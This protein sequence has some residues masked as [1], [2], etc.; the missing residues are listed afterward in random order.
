MVVGVRGKNQDQLLF[1]WSWSLQE[2]VNFND[3]ETC[4]KGGGGQRAAQEHGNVNPPPTLFLEI[5]RNLSIRS[6]RRSSF[7]P[8]LPI[9][10]SSHQPINQDG[11]NTNTAF[12]DF[13]HF[14][15]LINNHP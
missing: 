1:S 13:H 11:V 15:K 4:Y 12:D 9:D 5:F 14:L 3:G 8:L 6:G 7:C 10:S 2:L